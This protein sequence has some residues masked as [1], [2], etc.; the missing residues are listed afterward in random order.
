MRAPG[1]IPVAPASL[2]A[3]LLLPCGAFPCA[4]PTGGSLPPGFQKAT[5]ATG[6]VEPTAIAFA[7]DGRLFVAERAGAIRVVEGGDLLPQPLIQVPASTGVGERG[8]LGLALDP[9]F[10]ANGWLYAY[11]TTTEPR[12]RVGRFTVV[13]NAASP[14]SEFLVWQNPGLSA[15]FHQGGGIGFGP[16]GNLF[17]GAGDQ[18][19]T[20]NA[21]VLFTQHGKI[22]R[23]TAAGAIPPDN[24]FTQV[25]GAEGAIWAYG[26][27]NPFRFSFDPLTGQMWIG[28]IGGNTPTSWEELDPGVAGANY[29]WPAQEGGACY[30]PSCAAA[31]LPS[32]SYRHDDGAYS[33]IPQGCIVVGPVYRAGAFPPEYEGNL[34]V[35]DYANGWIRRVVFGPG[36][37]VVADPVFE[38]APDAGTVVDLA[39]GPDGSLVYVTNGLPWSGSAG[40][41]AVHR[42]AY[43]GTGNQAPVAVAAAIPAQ[44]P[45]PL[46][47]QFASAGSSD[48]D[49]GPSPL[50]FAWDFGDGSVSSEPDPSHVYAQE[51]PHTATLT[52]SDSAA[53]ASAAVS[54]VV[55]SPPS[56]AILAPPPGTTYRA[57]DRIDFLGSG[58][59]PE[60]GT[61]P[62]SSLSWQVVQ[63]HDAHAHPF[64]GPLPGVSEGGFTV[65]STGHPP[66]DSH[67]EIRLTVSDPSGLTGSAV[68]ALVPVPTTLVFDSTPSGVPFFLDGQPETTP[69]VVESLAGF[70]HEVQAQ[71]VGTVDGSPLAFECWSDGGGVSHAV[72][73]PEGGMNLTAGYG[74][75]WTETATFVV[76]GVLR[77]AEFSPP[78]G[79]EQGHPS[80]P[81]LI[82]WGEGTAGPLQAGFEY[83]LPVPQGAFVAQARL[84]MLAGFEQF[85]G[86]IATIR[87]YD[88]GGAPPFD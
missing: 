85:G 7:P 18:F 9:G 42:I 46:A 1:T 63:V 17:I 84:W 61:L 36:G 14:A 15:V 31:T 37:S 26:L 64:L 60:T 16:D 44:G 69:R 70:V 35:G 47:V 83:I 59:D 71:P 67:F 8:L 48:L 51:G 72:V 58:E 79:Q 21:Q 76:P 34:F 32:H 13:G 81:H 65:P 25:A 77:N 55:G 88:V 5:I 11:Y 3:L 4:P 52:V 78:F 22:L 80:N 10:A 68:R 27:R 20:P 23:V 40:P 41:G 53:Q 19:F 87:A 24:P 66:L 74:P 43:V 75:L 28:D 45:A 54:I 62:A 38:A 56:A 50:S 6:L 12:N 33:S 39:V 2:G 82:C 29:G 30:I 73:A 49:G 86:P 57:G